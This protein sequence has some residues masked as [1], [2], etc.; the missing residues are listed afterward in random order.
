MGAKSYLAMNVL[1]D[2]K[3]QTYNFRDV[4]RDS[5][6]EFRPFARKSSSHYVLS[7]TLSAS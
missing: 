5:M 1:E 4:D 7:C 6:R 2:V 3:S